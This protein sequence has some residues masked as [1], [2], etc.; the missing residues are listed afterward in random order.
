[1]LMNFTVSNYRGFKNSMNLDLTDVREYKFNK[2]CVKNGIINKSILYGKNAVGKTNLG[3]ALMDIRNT[4]LGHVTSKDT[5]VSYI[6]ADSEDDFAR[7]EYIFLIEDKKVEYMYEKTSPNTFKFESLTI[8]GKELYSYH[9][10]SQEGNFDGLKRYEELK[11]LNF[12]DWN[13]EI[14]VLRYILS[15][16]KLFQLKILTQLRDFIKGM[17]YLRPSDRFASFLGPTLVKDGMIKS[18]I[19][20]DL[21]KN[22]EVFL[23]ECGIDIPLKVDI[24]PEGEEQLYFN[25]KRSIKFIDHASSGTKALTSIYIMLKNID[26]IKFLFVDEFDSNLYFELAEN[27]IKQLKETEGFQMIATTHNTDLMN[28]KLMRP[29]VYFLMIENKI[30]PLANATNRELR[31]GHNLEKLYQSGEFDVEEREW[32]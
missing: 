15:N 25:Y 23:K 27:I 19:D 16:A 28:N 20:N 6:Y 12:I 22:F 31:M 29:D 4:I 26:K 2:E 8:D 18:I 30:T 21:V 17:V 7:F 1:M 5:D 32:G 3:L 24:T 13:N 10:N 11:H 9:F 14:S